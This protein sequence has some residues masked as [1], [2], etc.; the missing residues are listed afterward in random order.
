MKE[1]HQKLIGQS[2]GKVV[3]QDIIPFYVGKYRNYNAKVYCSACK[4]IGV[5]RLRSILSDSAKSCGCQK[6]KKPTGLDNKKCI[7]ICGEKFGILTPVK[8]DPHRTDRIYW[9]CLCDCGTRKSV[10]A[11]HLRNGS[12][13]SCGCQQYKI[14][15]DNP[16]WKGHEKISG[17]YWKTLQTNA[18]K[19]KLDFTISIEYAWSIYEKQCG[20]CAL[21]G[22][23]LTFKSKNDTCDGTASLDRIDSSKG[24]IDGNIQWVDKK[25]N[26]IKWDLS[27][28]NFFRVCK[29]VV[30]HNKL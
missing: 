7:D 22:L 6:H 18:Y 27:L 4:K 2:F 8:I 20:K 26:T 1:S 30:E 5:V 29:M 19:R 12:V 16:T 13:T 17:K 24:Y 11:K 10:A 9:E 28:D 3:I 23:P 15:K 21:T 25:V 14:G